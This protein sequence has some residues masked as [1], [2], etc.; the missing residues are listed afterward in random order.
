MNEAK[1]LRHVLPSPDRQHAAPLSPLLPIV[2]SITSLLSSLTNPTTSKRTRSAHQSISKSKITFRRLLQKS[3]EDAQQTITMSRPND[4]KPIPIP[5]TSTPSSAPKTQY[6]HNGRA[7]SSLPL[8]ARLSQFSES[9]Y[10]FLGLYFTTLFSVRCY[11]F[12]PHRIIWS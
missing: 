5:S 11:L 6:I 12:L 7:V 9:A 2:T 1:F 8:S 4:R 10:V 3:A